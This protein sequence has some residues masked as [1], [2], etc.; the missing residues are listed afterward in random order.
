MTDTIRLRIMQRDA[1]TCQYCG[2]RA[3]QV[4]HIRPVTAGGTH[5][6]E[7]LVAACRKCNAWASDRVFASFAEKN[8]TILIER[9]NPDGNLGP[10]TDDDCEP[11]G[12]FR[13][14]DQCLLII[15]GVVA[16][17]DSP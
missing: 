1:W 11:T 13:G 5:A 12:D 2:D 17:E 6:D 10:C 7:N 8:R 14:L 9:F 16:G 3:E 15:S 4:D